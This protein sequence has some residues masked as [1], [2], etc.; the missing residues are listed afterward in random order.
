MSLSTALLAS[1]ITC[2]TA[3]TIYAYHAFHVSNKITPPLVTFISEILKLVVAATFV[4]R[5]KT[6]FAGLLEKDS[7]GITNWSKCLRSAIPAALF[8]VNTLIFYTVL[9]LVSPTLLTVCILAKLPITAILYHVI[10]RKQRN[11]YAWTSLFWLC[12]GIVFFNV[13]TSQNAT[14]VAEKTLWFIAPVAGLV[15][16]C[17]GS[18]ASIH[19]EILTK[20]GEFWDSQFWLYTCMGPLFL[21][22][23]PLY[24]WN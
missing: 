3:R 1:F 14:G 8:L 5:S 13:R 2:E 22:F 21:L 10:V 12:I 24:K 6:G 9:P 18:A 11:V 23:N 16:A 4:Y 15:I 7:E 17:L 19:I 20:A